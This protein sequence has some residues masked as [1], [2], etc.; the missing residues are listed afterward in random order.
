MRPGYVQ[1]QRMPR[2]R[3]HRR[4]G[5][6]T[7]TPPSV[8]IGTYTRTMI[9]TAK[10]IGRATSW[11]DAR[12][13]S[14][15]ESPFFA[16]AEMSNDVLDHYDGSVYNQSEVNRSKA[17]QIAGD[18]GLHHAREG[19]QHGQRNGRGHDKPATPT[20]EQE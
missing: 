3:L 10:K 17:H 14:I 18:I 4:E 2:L 9:V 8:K 15:T 11:A 19:N 5:D 12:M 7:G 16:V 13:V 6:Y 1:E 20:A